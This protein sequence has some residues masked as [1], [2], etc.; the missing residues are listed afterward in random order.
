MIRVLVHFQGWFYT[1]QRN[2]RASMFIF[3]PSKFRGGGMMVRGPRD[4]NVACYYLRSSRGCPHS[5]PVLFFI[6]HSQPTPIHCPYPNILHP[7]PLPAMQRHRNWE[8]EHLPKGRWPRHDGSLPYKITQQP[9]PDPLPLSNFSRAALV[10]AS[11]T[12]STPSP[13]KLEHSRYFR[14]PQI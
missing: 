1:R 11:N 2:R 12:S 10:A 14:A 4:T 5:A 8:G 13:V 7:W 3:A 6:R 9:P